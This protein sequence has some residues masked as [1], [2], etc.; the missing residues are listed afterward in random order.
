MKFNLAAV[1]LGASQAITIEADTQQDIAIPEECLN[2][3]EKI[4]EASLVD[5]MNNNDI[6]ADAELVGEDEDVQVDSEAD[7]RIHV[8]SSAKKHYGKTWKQI[9][10]QNRHILN[11]QAKCLR[12]VKKHPG[13]QP[14]CNYC[15]KQKIPKILW[16]WDYGQKVWYRWSLYNRRWMYWGPSKSG[17]TATG[18]SWYKGYWH[19]GGFVYKFHGGKWWRYENRRWV[20]Y[21]KRV[22]VSPRIPVTQRYCRNFYM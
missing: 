3:E 18:W 4:D 14:V 12:F 9:N 22:E 7:R 20:V 19:H 2:T 10:A 17:F 16:K 6:D 21:K 11:T 8:K 15:R 13:H 5:Y 1:L